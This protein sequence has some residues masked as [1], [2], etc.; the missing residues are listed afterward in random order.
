M[1]IIILSCPQVLEDYVN[2]L[3]D[4][5]IFTILDCHQDLLSPKFCGK[6]VK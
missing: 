1:S 6:P 2:K 3:G 4:A 5:G